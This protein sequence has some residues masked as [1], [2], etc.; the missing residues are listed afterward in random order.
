[1]GGQVTKSRAVAAV[2]EVLREIVIVVIYTDEGS[3]VL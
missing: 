2:R 1:V 3:N